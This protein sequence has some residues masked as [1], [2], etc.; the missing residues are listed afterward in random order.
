MIPHEYC[1]FLGIQIFCDESGLPVHVLSDT[2]RAVLFAVSKGSLI[3][4]RRHPQRRLFVDMLRFLI[5]R[6]VGLFHDLGPLLEILADGVL[7]FHP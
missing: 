2:P 7:E 6:N 3:Q 4:T 1:I 5:D